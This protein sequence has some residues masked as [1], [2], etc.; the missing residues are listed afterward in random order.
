MKKRLLVIFLGLLCVVSLSGCKYMRL[1][2]FKSQFQNF[3]KYFVFIKSPTKPGVLCLHPLL[4]PDDILLLSDGVS[5]SVVKTT[6]GVTT[7][8]FI[9]KKDS[10]PSDTT[11]SVLTISLEFNAENKLT[12]AFYPSQVSAIFHPDFVPQLL[13]RVGAARVDV[14]AKGLEG[15]KSPFP[16]EWVPDR[17]KIVQHLGEPTSEIVSNNE[18]LLSYIYTLEGGSGDAKPY[19]MIAISPLTKKARW[20]QTTVFGSQMTIRLI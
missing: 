4:I 13:E 11:P 14:A 19:I 7:W 6:E 8:A 9:M 10:P 3:P 18:T 2:Q 1:L 20:V 12:T 16:E 15:D 5:P 17:S